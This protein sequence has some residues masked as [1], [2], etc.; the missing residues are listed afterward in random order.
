MIELSV[1]VSGPQIANH[2]VYDEEEL[3]YFFNEIE[4]ANWHDMAQ[5]I[6]EHAPQPG[7]IA[8]MLRTMADKIEGRQAEET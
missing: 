6:K 1:S 2:L 5:A 8:I 3:A 7:A 4:E